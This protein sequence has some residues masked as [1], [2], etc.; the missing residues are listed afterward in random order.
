[1]VVGCPSSYSIPDAPPPPDICSS[2]SRSSSS[3]ALTDFAFADCCCPDSGLVDESG[4]EGFSDGCL[5]D[6]FDFSS[7]IKLST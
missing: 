6:S 7:R 4:A 3:V 5:L 1:M 2:F